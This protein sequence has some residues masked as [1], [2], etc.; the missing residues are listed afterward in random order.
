MDKRLRAKWV[1]AKDA[2]T[3]LP[4]FIDAYLDELNRIYAGFRAGA[5]ANPDTNGGAVVTNL[6]GEGQGPCADAIAFA[7]E[8]KTKQAKELKQVVLKALPLFAH[9]YADDDAYAAVMQ[10]YDNAW[11]GQDVFTPKWRSDGLRIPEPNP[12]DNNRVTTLV[13]AP[14]A[15]SAALN[16]ISSPPVEKTAPLAVALAVDS[17]GA[18]ADTI[19]V[20]ATV[21][22][23]K[24]PYAYEWSGARSSANDRALYD[25]PLLGDDKARARLQVKDASGAAASSVLPLAAPKITLNLIK[26]SPASNQV[27]AGQTVSFAVELK[28]DGKPVD[29][30][31]YTLRWEPNTQAHF[32]NAEDLGVAAN[33]ATF[34]RLGKVKVWVVA[35]AKSGGALAT[36]AESQ[37]IELEVVGVDIALTVAPPAPLVGQ[38]ARI[39]AKE[40]PAIPDSDAAY[41]WEYSGAALTP[42][43][44]AD[45]RVYSLIPKDD[46]PITVTAHLKERLHGDDLG[47]KSVAFNARGYN[48]TIANLGPAWENSTQRP[49]IWKPGQ[50]IVTLDK[51]IVAGQDVGFR[52]DVSPDGAAGPLRYR[53]SAGPGTSITGNDAGQETRAQRPDVGDIVVNV[54]VR[55]ARDVALGAASASASVTIGAAEF[56]DGKAKADALPKLKAEAAAAWAA[57]DIDAACD[58]GKAAAAIDPSF[59]AGTG[60]CK[61][62]QRILALVSDAQSALAKPDFDKAAS[63]I[64]AARA[65]NPK[66]KSVVDL[67]QKIAEARAAF[68]KATKSIGEADQAWRSGDAETAAQKAKDALA[69]MPKL[70]AAQTA[71]K[72]YGD[73][74]AALQAARSKAKA[75][76]DKRRVR[77]RARGG[78]RG[79]EDSRQ[80]QGAQ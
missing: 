48:V 58:K 56:A 38:E 42:G 12:C 55:D 19:A 41:W 2:L 39:T 37:Q 8:L 44:T 29:P 31:G 49:T 45:P 16:A 5:P 73:A 33:N 70:A 7:L 34:T 21:S 32:T 66:E 51:E 63:D 26:T 14:T 64:D 74:L 67:Q 1:D 76:L 6:E 71:A 22:G 78:R 10:A 47:S 75:A 68:D 80:R 3:G 28:A 40:T 50:G 65:I 62:R 52:A 17:R 79:Q 69:A 24:P 11:G 72:R 59:T 9:D 53:W 25:V 20:A 57:G 4:A 13:L 30:K 27:R 46:K 15:S 43:P 18:R 36:V 60:Y 23:G 35:L 77:R 54:E 61:D